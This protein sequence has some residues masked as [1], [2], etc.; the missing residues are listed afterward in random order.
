M[1]RF[2]A[3]LFSAVASVLLTR[4]FLAVAGYPQVGGSGGL[5]IAHVLWGGLLMAVGVVMMLV[6]MGSH[7]RL[8]AAVVAG[9]GFGLFIDEI[10]KF[11]TKTVDYFYQPAVAIMYVVFVAFYLVVRELLRL[12][13]LTTGRRLAVAATALADQSL[14]EL[15]EIHR[16]SALALIEDL[17]ESAAVAIRAALLDAPV[18][19]SRFEHRMTAWRDR[20]VAAT[21]RMSARRGVRIF[22]LCIVGFEIVITL[23]AAL[24]SFTET[25]QIPP[26][27][28]DTGAL[29]SSIAS[30]IVM[31]IGVVLLVRGH[32]IAGL[33]SLA[34]GLT[35]DL[36]VTTVFQ[37]AATQ[38]VALISFAVQLL[39]LIGVRTTLQIDRASSAGAVDAPAEPAEHSPAPAR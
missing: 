31:S 36:L 34:A 28:S 35:I 10:G 12:R 16:R 21:A 6:G 14:G 17:P 23:F 29:L 11:L 30:G 19:N 32:R 24:V 2:E 27:A 39:L 15:D 33:R 8:R 20:L 18:C 5:H 1:G 38:F 22:G 13:R 7:N 4:A 37:F 26:S 9:I 3:F 25:P